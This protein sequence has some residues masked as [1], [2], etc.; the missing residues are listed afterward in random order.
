MYQMSITIKTLAPVVF[1]TNSGDNVLTA[2]KE[3]F[4]GNV[5]RGALA[6][7]YINGV[8]L[9]NPSEDV[10]FC[11]LFLSGALRYVAAYVAKD[12]DKVA[13]PLP[14]SLMLSKKA[15]AA[16]KKELR[17]LTSGVAAEAG[18]KALRG[19]GYLS[20][21]QLSRAEVRKNIELHMS[22]SS[23][24]ER[25]LGRSL[26][27]GIYNYEAICADQCF[28]GYVEGSKQDLESLA[29]ALEEAGLV[30]GKKI[31][32][33]GRSKNTQYGKCS[34]Q[35]GPIKEKL[36]TVPQ[37]GKA[38]YVYAYTDFIPGNN[39]FIE[40]KAALQELVEAL[41]PV[42]PVA[43]TEIYATQGTVDNFVGVWGAKRTR[44]RCIDKGAII[45]LQKL[46]GTNWTAA[47]LSKVN[48]ILSEGLGRLTVEGYGQ[49]RL[50]EPKKNLQLQAAKG[51]AKAAKPGSI[52][53]EVKRVASAIIDKH[54]YEQLQL[55]AAEGVDKAKGLGGQNHF[56]CRMEN[57]VADIAN[58]TDKNLIPNIWGQEIR[59]GSKAKVTLE[60]IK[61][62]GYS[63]YECVTLTNH[64]G[65][66]SVNALPYADSLKTILTG[67]LAELAKT[68][69]YSLPAADD[70]K[71][72]AT[73][74]TWFFRLAR[75]KKEGGKKND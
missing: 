3:Y 18:Y 56:A 45:G 35:V 60:A 7:T 55:L 23:D 26:D 38:A 42:T 48:E 73:Y 15:D 2:T 37:A 34:L 28:V 63:L 58:I 41:E 64:D 6:R 49:L 68:V 54:I 74:W 13:L 20:G 10:A 59:P 16:G 52:P 32:Y 43:V 1:S 8:G 33:F 17:D 70:V 65:R 22:R 21:S 69:G 31:V 14:S 71:A 61:L 72:Y 46:D 12:E 66:R 62:G 9:A 36:A 24:E 19:F 4:S 5:L 30:R 53:E 47:E 57:I 67:E 51:E 25:K 11:R 50:W 29:A 44:L 75:K 27:G 40:I 39:G